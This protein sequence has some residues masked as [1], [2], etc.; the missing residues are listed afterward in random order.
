MNTLEAVYEHLKYEGDPEENEIIDRKRAGHQ[1]RMPVQG[2]KQR[3]VSGCLL[4]VH[5]L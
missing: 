3:Y 5:P 1:Y 2:K 4:T